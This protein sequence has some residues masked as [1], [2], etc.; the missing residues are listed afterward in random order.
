VYNTRPAP[1][2]STLP[3]LEEAVLTE[4]TLLAAVA[5][6]P[7]LK[8]PVVAAASSVDERGGGAGLAD[9]MVLDAV[10]P[11][12]ANATAE[13]SASTIVGTAMVRDTRLISQIDW[14]MV[15]RVANPLRPGHGEQGSQL[16]MRLGDRVQ[17]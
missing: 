10:L 9:A 1:S 8:R 3:Y 2:N 7:V 14:G 6:G 5:L 16:R 4:G 15:C 12:A 11:Q 13:P 17:A